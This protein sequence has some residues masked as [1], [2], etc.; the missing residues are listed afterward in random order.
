MPKYTPASDEAVQQLGDDAV[1][2][3]KT[4]TKEYYLKHHDGTAWVD[5]IIYDIKNKQVKLFPSNVVDIIIEKADPKLIL[6]DTATGGAERRFASTGGRAAILDSTDAIVR[7]IENTPIIRNKS[8]TGVTIGASGS[9]ATIVS[10]SLAAGYKNL[11]PLR[12]TASVSGLA[13]GESA[14]IRL[15]AVLDDGSVV[16]LATATGVTGSVTFTPADIDY[17]KIPDGKRVTEVRVTAE[18]SA[19]TTSA[20]ADATIVLEEI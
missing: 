14:T 16:N 3:Y 1:V 8:A 19:T 6:K 10:Y 5:V 15:D 7:E 12:A 17:S 20:T 18:S 11:L 2:I 4:S 9:P 13:T